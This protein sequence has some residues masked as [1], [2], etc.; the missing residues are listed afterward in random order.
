LTQFT[1]SSIIADDPRWLEEF[2][3]PQKGPQMPDRL[4][5]GP[6][7]VISGPAGDVPWYMVSFDRN[8]RCTAPRTAQELVGRAASGQYTDVV[9]FSH[10]W[11]N[12][13]AQATARYESFVTGYLQILR[14]YPPA[15]GPRRPLLAG[16]FWPSITLVTG[17]EA[18]PD[19]AGD[20]G[21]DA[22]I[23]AERA[24]I[25][26]LGQA[27]PDDQ[28]ERFYDLIQ[29]EELDPDA[30]RE[31]TAMFLPLLD[32]ELTEAGDAQRP[33]PE[34]VMAGWQAAPAARTVPDLDELGYYQAEGP[35]GEAPEAAG[36]RGFDP[37]DL[38]RAFTVWQMK[39]R[40][41]VVGSRGVASLLTDLLAQPSLPVHCVGHSYGA[42]VMLTAICAPRGGPA[43][44]RS[45]LLLQPAVSALCFAADAGGTGRAG[46]FR[47]ALER[48]QL[49]ILS[50][51]S[52]H[53]VPLTRFYRW[54]MRRGQDVGEPEVAGTVPSRYAALGGS[55][56]GGLG[57][58]A[59]VVDV[60]DP[61]T[62]YQLGSSPLRVHGIQATRT[63]SSHG[64]VSNPSTWWMM[65][66]LL[67]G[68]R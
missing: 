6:Y 57:A 14:E 27:L 43:S 29:R 61:G 38:V 39:D 66:Q 67:H 35:G 31:L 45:A 52:A 40:A 65:Q 68:P 15:D 32:S 7:R 63:I 11:N 64:D 12:D 1:A 23:A 18:A 22:G 30:A 48:V 21:A 37:R 41:G 53:D 5:A 9:V 60:L 26:E 2:A 3:H 58:A 8:G 17:S 59:D 56:P 47:A 42:K 13:W 50:T 62:P 20:P 4:P 49:P 51:F 54:A 34:A 55:G 33:A 24:V 10:G 25:E 16:I 46:G 44:V 36:L 19:I 28:T